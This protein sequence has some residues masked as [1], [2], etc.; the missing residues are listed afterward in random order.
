MAVTAYVVAESLISLSR[1]KQSPVSNLKLQKLL[2]YTQAWHLVLFKRALFAEEFEAWVHGPVVPAVFRRYRASGWMALD[3]P[4]VQPYIPAL[5][6]K[7]LKEVWKAYGHLSASDLERLTH[8]ESPWIKARKG[9]PPDESSH[10]I[11][12]KDSMRK[13][14]SSR[15][16]G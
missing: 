11:I 3:A 10:E 1:E 8:S 16:H 13:Y 4:E 2:Y 7:H 9:L 5:V 6:R 12:T 14:Y 15:L